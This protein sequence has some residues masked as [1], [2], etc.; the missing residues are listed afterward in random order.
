MTA[1]STASHR[2]KASADVPALGLD[3]GTT[4]TVAAVANADGRTDVLTF[5]QGAEVH[6]V[7]RSA[8]CF[9]QKR[10]RPGVSENRIEAG[11]WGIER[12]AE[13][14]QDCRFLQSF[15]TF[16]ASKAFSDTVAQ[17][18][19]YRFED[20]LATFLK[21]LESH[22]DT[23]IGEPRPRLVIGRPVTFAG[24]DPDEALATARYRAGL[25]QLGF[26]SVDFVYEP[27]AAAY[28]YAQRLETSATIL[29]ADFGGGTSDFSI[30]RFHRHADGLTAEPLG[31]SGVGIAG[32]TFDYRIIDN[33]IS[34]RLGK[35]TRY[36][37]FDKEL[38]IPVHYFA[39]FARWNHL[40][41]MKSAA[42]LRE[43][44]DL[45]N[46][47]VDRSGLDRLI[48]LLE[49][50][51]TWDVYRAVSHAKITLSREERAELKLHA[52]SIRI[53]ATIARSDFERWIAQDL[54]RIEASVDEALAKAAVKPASIDRVFLTGGSS[55]LPAIRHLFE[56][57]FGAARIETGDQ[58]VSIAYGLALIGREKDLGSWRVDASAAA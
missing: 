14:P 33:V 4:N 58:L 31:A 1:T 13:D 41:L 15:K 26:S 50:D 17:G 11:P 48:E 37:S 16:A 43:L 5:T 22:A 56:R 52:G 35:G 55:Y 10:V 28:F 36:R 32:D 54:A 7:F 45:A 2:R 19:R 39:N 20:L 49:D 44:E 42:T 53:D 30:I 3:F 27:V 6:G 24:A 18:K 23:P 38:D 29:V 21:K 12:F 25:E 34:P 51:L 40:A 47:S 8:L 46:Q 9:F 57:R